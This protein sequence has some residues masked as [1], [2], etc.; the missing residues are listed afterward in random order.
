MDGHEWIHVQRNGHK[1]MKE[2]RKGGKKKEERKKGWK[3][4]RKKRRNEGTKRWMIVDLNA[5]IVLSKF[6][7]KAMICWC[8]EGKKGRKGEQKDWS[9][10]I[11]SQYHLQLPIQT[12]LTSPVSV[13]PAASD[14][15]WP[16]NTHV[17]CLC[18]TCSFRHKQH[19]RHLSQYHLQLPT[20]TTLTSPVLSLIHIW[21]CRRITGCRSRWSPYH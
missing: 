8:E 12:T 6:T 3:E 20:Q 18:T 14:T 15:D 19:S 16:N 9:F 13:P 1:R 2:G 7:T 4:R 10:K 5:W 11:T 21:R 17:T